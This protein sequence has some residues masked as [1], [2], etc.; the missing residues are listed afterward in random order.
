[1]E[2]S[3]ETRLNIIKSIISDT[4]VEDQ[5]Q[6]VEIL[7]RKGVH[8]SQP[9]LSRDIRELKIIK[10]QNLDGKSVY[11]LPVPPRKK[12]DEMNSLLIERGVIS[13]QFSG[14]VAVMKTRPGY[15]SSVAYEIDKLSTGEII[16]TIAGCD[17]ILLVINENT[18]KE[19]VINMLSLLIT[20][21]K[22][23]LI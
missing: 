13:M 5:D 22:N 12:I 11:M 20:D 16:G 7:K 23:K 21:L 15:A 8:I 9:T 6:L 14:N 4:P 2:L 3:R 19:K 1:M 18:T 17:T 10:G